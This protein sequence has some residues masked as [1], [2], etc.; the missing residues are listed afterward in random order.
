MDPP[1]D[2]R[3][4]RDTEDRVNELT[5]S[6]RIALVD[7]ADLAFSDCMHRLVALDSSPGTFRRTEAEARCNAFLDEPMVLLDDVIQIRRCSTSAAT[8]EVS[9]FPQLGDRAG[10]RRMPVDV[11]HSWPPIRTGHCQAEEQLRRN[12]VAF[13]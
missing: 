11:D 12:Q 3:L 9:R 13:R 5:L 4:R 8:S 10:I 2:R 6:H 1:R 7:P